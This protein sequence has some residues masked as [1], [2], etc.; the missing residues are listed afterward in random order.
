MASMLDRSIYSLN[1]GDVKSDSYLRQL[2]SSVPD[3]AILLIEDIDA[4]LNGRLVIAKGSGITFS[5]LLNVMSGVFDKEG[6]ITIVTTN[7]P[8]SLDPALMR[9]GRID[10]SVE[11]SNPGVEQINKYIQRFYGDQTEWYGIDS[12]NYISNF[13][14]MSDIQEACLLNREDPWAAIGYIIKSNKKKK[15]LAIQVGRTI[16]QSAPRGPATERVVVKGK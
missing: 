12:K 6:L 16:Y 8:E 14:S 1:L 7:H 15:H 4:I 11:V 10:V 9:T 3:D 2:F 13:L 5:G